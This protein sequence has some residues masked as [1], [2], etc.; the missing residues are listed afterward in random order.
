M[1]MS[2]IVYT[3]I[4]WIKWYLTREFVHLYLNE[5]IVFR[6]KREIMMIMY[7]LI[8]YWCK[9]N[10][11]YKNCINNN[12]NNSILLAMLS[13]KVVIFVSKVKS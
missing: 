11:A 2:L 1:T 4:S 5:M 12:N 9:F 8:Y 10:A 13:K 6:W 3:I 7:E